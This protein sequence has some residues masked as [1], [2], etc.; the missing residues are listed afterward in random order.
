MH[1][2]ENPGRVIVLPTESGGQGENVVLF[3][4]PTPTKGT[5]MTGDEFDVEIRRLGFS[6]LSFADF[7]GIGGRTART[8]AAK[9]P[10]P[11]AQVL[12]RLL[13]ERHIPGGWRGNRL[14]DAPTVEQTRE[15]IEPAVQHIIDR[16][17]EQHWDPTTIA[18]ALSAIAD[19]LRASAVA[20]PRRATSA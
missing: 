12:L 15:A 6:Q 20:E 2:P 19:D 5:H 3:P 4:C 8:Y 17:V 18:Y 11:I 9:G 13:A 1:S 16:A 7:A 14:L 10:P